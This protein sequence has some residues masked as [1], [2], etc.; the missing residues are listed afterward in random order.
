MVQDS[1]SLFRRTTLISLVTLIVPLRRIT[2]TTLIPPVRL[3][4]L[5]TSLITPILLRVVATLKAVQ[6]SESETGRGTERERVAKLAGA[7]ALR[8]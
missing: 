7:V 1:Y 5:I 2:R 3:I 4:A 6:P 8:G